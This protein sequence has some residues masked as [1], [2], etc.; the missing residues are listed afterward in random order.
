MNIYDVQEL[1]LTLYKKIEEDPD[2][3]ENII[4]EFVEEQQKAKEQVE[5]LI[6]FIKHLEYQS[7][8]CLQEIKR[9]QDRKKSNDNKIES[10]KKYL[11]PFVK[12]KGRYDAGTFTLSTRLSRLVEVDESKLPNN[13]FTTRTEVKPDKKLI[14]ELLDQGQEVE[15]AKIIEKDNLQIK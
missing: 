14:K 2:N 10:I 12:E 15:G 7:D 6:K 9:I 1:E 3:T 13:M 11:T 8:I 5:R 4:K